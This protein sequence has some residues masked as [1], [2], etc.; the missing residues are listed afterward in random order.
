VARLSQIVNRSREVNPQTPE[1]GNVLE[2]PECREVTG[3]GGIQLYILFGQA[4]VD[5]IYTWL[6]LVKLI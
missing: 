1:R 6:I 5:D 4:G 2:D 3:L